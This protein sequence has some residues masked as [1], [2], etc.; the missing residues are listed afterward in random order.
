MLELDDGEPASRLIAWPD[1]VGALGRFFLPEIRT[2]A[3]FV[4][5]RGTSTHVSEEGV[6]TPKMPLRL[7]AQ[8]NPKHTLAT[9]FAE[10]I[11][12][13]LWSHMDSNLFSEMADFCRNWRL[14]IVLGVGALSVS[15]LACVSNEETNTCSHQAMFG[16]DER[17][18]DLP[19]INGESGVVGIVISKTDTP[20]PEPMYCSGALLSNELIITA[21]HCVTCVQCKIE[22]TFDSNVGHWTTGTEG[23]LSSSPLRQ[24]KV[25]RV[26]PSLDLALLGLTDGHRASRELAFDVAESIP[27][28]GSEALLGGFGLSEDGIG[29]R[30]YI[31]TYVSAVTGSTVVVDTDGDEGACEGDSGGPL[32][33]SDTETGTW[34]LVANLSKG[35]GLCI[36]PDEYTSVIGLSDWLQTDP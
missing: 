2:F 29:L 6:F 36:G 8:R 9:V 34:K 10:L 18:Y 7:V 27:I 14:D 28:V 15:A 31:K 23:C 20:K 11:E 16:G 32:L 30:R 4:T 17:K 25:I 21:K 13:H 24:A 22:V 3:F 33:I 35:S 26:H 12:T 5:G 1:Q 19:S